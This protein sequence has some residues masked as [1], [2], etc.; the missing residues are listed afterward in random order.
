MMQ[1]FFFNNCVPPADRPGSKNIFMKTDHQEVLN[2]GRVR[3]EILTDETFCTIYAALIF[4]FFF[5]V[6]HIF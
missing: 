4:T 1:M 5:R 6:C 2:P 3:I